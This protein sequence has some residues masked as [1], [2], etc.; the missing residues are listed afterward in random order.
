[1][2]DQYQEIVAGLSGLTNDQLRDV[3]ERI[4]G[5]LS[6]S[7][8][9]SK[10]EDV[11]SSKKDVDEDLVL[12]AI[13]EYLESEGLQIVS[14]GRLKNSSVYKNNASKVTSV[15]EWSKRVQSRQGRSA[16]LYLGVQ[17]LCDYLRDGVPIRWDGE[18]KYLVRARLP[19][20]FDTVLSFIDHLPPVLDNAFPGYA[21]S[22][23]L[24]WVIKQANRT[25]AKRN[26]RK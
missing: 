8:G 10:V 14:L 9:A 7:S 20:S 21:K 11:A 1:M 15:A 12:V 3:R 2:T 24:D 13:C 6:L 5:L 25:R 16:I 18:N 23:K 19:V 22:G 4:T 26:V 17:L